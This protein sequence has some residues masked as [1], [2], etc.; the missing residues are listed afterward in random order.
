MSFMKTLKK[1]ISMKLNM[2][3]YQLYSSSKESAA[4]ERCPI[5]CV[6]PGYCPEEPIPS[7]NQNNAIPFKIDYS[8]FINEMSSKRE[9]SK[10]R[11]ITRLLEKLPPDCIKFG[12][13]VPNVLTFPFKKI[14]VELITGENINLEGEELS[15]ALQYLPSVGYRPLIKILEEI[16]ESY[17]GP[18]NWNE[19]SI[20]MTSGA[21]EGLSKVVDMCMR[22][23]DP[24]IMPD[25]VYTGAVDL[26]KPYN[27]DIIPIVQDSCGVIVEEIEKVLAERKRKMMPIPKM[28]YLNPTASNPA[29]TTMPT[30]R[31]RAIYKLACEYNML[32]LE[33][34]PYY[35]LLFKKEN[36]VSFLSMDTEGRV[37]R[38]DSFSKIMSS[39]LRVGFVTGP[40]TLV[41]RIELH[42]QTSSMHTSSLS[43]V[44]LYKLLSHWGKDGLISHFMH[45]QNFYK[46]KLD[47]MMSAIKKNLNGLAEWY[48]PNGGMFLWLKIIGLNDAKQL[49]ATRCLDKLIILAPGYALSA[50]TE[51]PSP[52][53]RIS[54][55]IASPEEVDRG[56]SLLAEAIREELSK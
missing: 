29:G 45:V 52:Y 39:G 37:L 16:Q 11:E 36:P 41:R 24:V 10:L 54:Y 42:M 20:I 7:Y 51:K 4:V 35:Y 14:S 49:V 47:H 48:E 56:I 13:G 15:D 5:D 46:Q 44:L 30:H 6:I 22:C 18:Q 43:Q 8:Y 26:F 27:A 19:R 9:P 28:I 32:I 25:P 40:I 33:D 1:N 12:V 55:S 3:Q 50:N 31:K 38:F 2:A 21:Q 34:D 53:I 23:N 17:H